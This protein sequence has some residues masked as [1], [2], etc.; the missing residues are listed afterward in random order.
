LVYKIDRCPRE[1][2]SQFSLAETGPEGGE[3]SQEIVFEG[4]TVVGALIPVAQGS[5]H[6]KI[7]ATSEES[8]SHVFIALKLQ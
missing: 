8:K 2:L 7:E 6:Y 5:G 4:N 1:P 3:R